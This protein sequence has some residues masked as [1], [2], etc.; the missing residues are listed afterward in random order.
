MDLTR[1]AATQT[2]AKAALVLIPS[3]LTPAE[4]VEP[5]CDCAR[6]GVNPVSGRPD[7]LTLQ[8]DLKATAR[9]VVVTCITNT[10]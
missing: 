6:T 4:A 7:R 5:T 9:S 2:V 1:Q 3:N 8:T 10:R